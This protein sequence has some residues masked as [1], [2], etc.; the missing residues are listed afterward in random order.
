MHRGDRSH[1]HYADIPGLF[2]GDHVGSTLPGGRCSVN[3]CN[4]LW[5]DC[6]SCLIDCDK[7]GEVP[8][9]EEAKRIVAIPTTTHSPT[10][11]TF[12]PMITCCSDRTTGDPS[13]YLVFL[14]TRAELAIFASGVNPKVFT[15]SLSPKNGGA[16]PPV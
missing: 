7:L 16:N 12:G 11:Q 1:F 8:S 6:R 3:G 4:Q 13:L 9:G 10:W 5:A 2:A 14:S 15:I